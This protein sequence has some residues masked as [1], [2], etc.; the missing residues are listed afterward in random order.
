MYPRKKKEKKKATLENMADISGAPIAASGVELTAP[1]ANVELD[2]NKVE[3]AIALVGD[4]IS[5]A[6]L[7]GVIQQIITDLSGSN[8]GV[9]E[10]FRFVPVL[11]A[12]A[13][14]LNVSKERKRDLVLAAGHQLVDRVIVEDMRVDGHHVIDAVFPGALAGVVDLAR[15][16]VSFETAAAA[17]VQAVSAPVVLEVAQR[18]CLPLILSCL[19]K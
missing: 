2:S 9:G 12:K 8:P 16:R 10:L 18:R 4:L 6:D 11:A 13:Q 1:A 17:V 5:V 15:G 14:T 19:K 7:S 3:T